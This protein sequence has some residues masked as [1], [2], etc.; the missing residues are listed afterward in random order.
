[1]G[2]FIKTCK[3]KKSGKTYL[4][5]QIVQSYRENGKVRHKLIANLGTPSEQDINSLIRGLNRIRET[6][7]S[8]EQAQLQCKKILAFGELAVLDYLWQKMDIDT[9]IHN[10]TQSL[11]KVQFDISPY[12]KLMVFHRLLNPGS[13]LHLAECFKGIYFPDCDVLEYHKL[14]R[15]ITYVMRN[16]DQ[17]EEQLFKK[18]KDIFHLDVDPVFYDITSTYFEADGPATAKKGYSRDKRNDRNQV[19]TAL[20][21]TKDGYAIGHEVFEGNMLDKSTVK[22]TIDRLKR[23]FSIDTCIFVGDRGMV[24][25]ENIK[26]MEEQGYRYIFA[27]RR[28]RLYETEE[29]IE[30][31]Y[32]QADTGASGQGEACNL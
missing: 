1:M 23:R 11:P 24:T 2:M 20:A 30:A 26:Y 25:A 15:S 10:C 14:L 17:I 32:R 21:V 18:Q 22:E 9:I 7:I 8:L 12:I 27:L 4:H 6:P 29:V 16:K 5:Y 28:R 13:E 31:D 19:L 3:S